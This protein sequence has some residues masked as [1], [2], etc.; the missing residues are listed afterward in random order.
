MAELLKE[1][2]GINL[3]TEARCECSG[4][5][6]KNV[7][8]RMVEGLCCPTR[9]PR[10]LCLSRLGSSHPTWTLGETPPPTVTEWKGPGFQRDTA[11]RNGASADFTWPR[12]SLLVPTVPLGQGTLRHII[13]HISLDS[14]RNHRN[15]PKSDLKYF[16]FQSHAE[17]IN[18]KNCQ[19]LR[20]ATQHLTFPSLGMCLLFY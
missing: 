3:G 11:R 17:F 8:I 6:L 18:A 12:H 19:G 13:A 1:A 7:C 14:H 20:S 5:C 2:W 9:I 16:S 15:S 4:R 10:S